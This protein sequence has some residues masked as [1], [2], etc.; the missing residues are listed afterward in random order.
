MQRLTLTKLKTEVQKFARQI[1][2]TPIPSLY[3]I[4]DG[5]AVG[6]YV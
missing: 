6:T 2:D 4:T 3:G 1:S 5:K